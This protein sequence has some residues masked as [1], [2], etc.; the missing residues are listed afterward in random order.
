MSATAQE[1]EFRYEI[2][3]AD[4]MIAVSSAWLEF[5]QENGAP[6]LHEAAV[7]NRSLWDHIADEQTRRLYDDLF[8]AVRQRNLSLTLPFRCDSPHICRYMELHLDPA[9][10]AGIALCGILLRREPGYGFSFHG[11][12]RLRTEP[13]L[14]ICSLC[15][16]ICLSPSDWVPTETAAVR[17]NLFDCPTVPRI[18]HTICRNCRRIADNVS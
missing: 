10:N 15:Q 14:K 3:D 6:Q 11:N 9:G 8:Q 5:A 1:L 4:R 12:D 13:P 16:R 18:D 17:L 2:D 7:L